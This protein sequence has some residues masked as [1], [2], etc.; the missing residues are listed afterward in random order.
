MVAIAVRLDEEFDAQ[1]DDLE[2]VGTVR[3]F[4]GRPASASASP[5]RSLSDVI[6][7]AILDHAPIGEIAC[8]GSGGTETSRSKE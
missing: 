2:F 7:V 8:G 4:R 3:A 6:A 5:A 1:P